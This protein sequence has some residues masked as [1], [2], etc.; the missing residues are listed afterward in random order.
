M[1]WLASVVFGEATRLSDPMS[2]LDRPP[3]PWMFAAFRGIFLQVSILPPLIVVAGCCAT[4]RGYLRM[5][6]EQRPRQLKIDCTELRNCFTTALFAIMHKHRD[7]KQKQWNEMGSINVPHL[8]PNEAA[9]R[10]M[11]WAQ[12][13]QRE[14]K[15]NQGACSFFGASPACGK[16]G[17]SG[18]GWLSKREAATTEVTLTPWPHG[19]Q[20]WERSGG[21]TMGVRWDDGSQRD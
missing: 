12:R 8:H 15:R 3:L 16:S 21:S 1:V 13:S 2:R 5:K 9:P 11:V 20:R 17:P 14:R 18:F 6:M 4:C 10:G 19:S 7:R